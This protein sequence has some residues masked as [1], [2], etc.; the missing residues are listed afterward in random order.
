MTTW[1]YQTLLIVDAITEQ[2]ETGLKIK[3]SEMVKMIV[4]MRAT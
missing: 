4:G 3:I 1:E 2:E